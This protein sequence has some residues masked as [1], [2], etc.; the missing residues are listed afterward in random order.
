MEYIFCVDINEGEITSFEANS[1]KEAK[2]MF[3]ESFPK[4]IDKITLITSDNG[5]E[6]IN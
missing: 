6:E 5:Y 2:E 4:D 3:A 1:L